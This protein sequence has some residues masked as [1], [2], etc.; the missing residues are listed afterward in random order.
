MKSS[1]VYTSAIDLRDGINFNSL[2]SDY[3]I[4][5][6]VAQTGTSVIGQRIVSVPNDAIINETSIGKAYTKISDEYV[7]QNGVK[8]FIY[9][10]IRA[11][12]EEEVNEYMEILEEYY[13]EWKEQYTY[14]DKAVLMG[15]RI[16]GEGIG[17]AKR[18]KYDCVYMLPGFTPTIYTIKTNKKVE[19]LK[20]R[21]YI[22]E[23]GVD[24]S[25][26]DYGK[27]KLTIEKDDTI[28][29]DDNVVYGEPQEIELD[30]SDAEN[31]QFTVDKDGQLSWDNLYMEIK[32]V[33]LINN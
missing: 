16:L 20:L 10:K 28:I 14:F 5:T 24:T 17:D 4:V 22:D 26:E 23:N 7:L 11:F 30:L 9:K 3:I 21:L 32:D 1:I 2:M 15:E 13:P 12:T 19:K 25:T 29:Y 18:Y 8:A 31:L 27:V 6:D 33:K